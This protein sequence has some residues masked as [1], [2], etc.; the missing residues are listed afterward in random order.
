[1]QSIETLYNITGGGILTA[2]YNVS[3]QSKE[4]VE[5]SVSLLSSSHMITGV[6]PDD[7]Y[8]Q[9]LFTNSI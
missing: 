8:L 9:K 7:G 5:R 4:N 3:T 6:S 2:V 1:M